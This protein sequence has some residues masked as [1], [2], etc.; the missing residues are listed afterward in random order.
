[1][2]LV[3]FDKM[4]TELGNIKPLLQEVIYAVHYTE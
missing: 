1:M 2:Y 4:S 3:I